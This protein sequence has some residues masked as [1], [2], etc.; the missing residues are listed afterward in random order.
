[1]S[2]YKTLHFFF[3]AFGLGHRTARMA[4]SNTVF[5]PF[6]VRAEHSRYFTALISFAIAR[7]CGYVIGESF[8]SRNF[9]TV[10]LSSL[11]SSFVPTRMIGVLGQWWLTSGYHY[12]RT[13]ISHYYIAS[14][15]RHLYKNMA[16]IY[17]IR[18]VTDQCCWNLSVMT[19]W[20]TKK[21]SD[22]QNFK[23][24]TCKTTRTDTN[25]WKTDKLK[26]I[27]TTRH[28]LGSAKCVVLHIK[29]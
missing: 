5:R 24:F 8:F 1:M 20:L 15:H 2:N 10:S 16:L 7:P 23:K 21:F 9:S 26:R 3:L 19:A 25:L 17:H 18:L 28:R 12:K 13:I 4:S 29:R 11:R 14:N 6:C 27:P 22:W